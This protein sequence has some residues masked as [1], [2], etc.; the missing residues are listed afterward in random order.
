MRV[1]V[2]F[3]LAVAA[4]AAVPDD[5]H[6]IVGG[7][8]TTI[9][10]YPTMAAFL[11]AHDG[12]NFRQNCG[13]TILNNRSVLT[14][15]HCTDGRVAN[16]IRIRVGSTW[17][18]SGGVVHNIAFYINHPSYNPHTINNDVAVMRSAT[19]I[20]HNNNVRPVAIAGA[21]YHLADNQ[22]V[23]TAGWGLTSEGGAPSEQ[24]RHVQ[25]YSINQATCRSR[26]S[27]LTDNM[28]C[29][30]VLNV[31]GRSPCQMDSGGPTYHNG[32]Q[33]GITSFGTGCGRPNFPS[34]TARVSRF[35]SWITSNA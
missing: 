4:V 22:V 35:A 27:M 9:G 14:A 7:S 13:S 17:A 6:R 28:L 25:V 18:N 29:I 24:L 10:Q 16:R 19:T 34:V 30:G 20:V 12:V 15:A 11:V 3:A 32:V 2:L 5:T 31:G 8:V 26:Y 23:W 33:V 1:I 21:N